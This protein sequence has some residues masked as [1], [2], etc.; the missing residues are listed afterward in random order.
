MRTGVAAGLLVAA[1]H[2][3]A[4]ADF[5]SVTSPDYAIDLYTGGAIGNSRIVGMGGASVATAEGSAGALTNAAAPAVR[6]ATSTTSWDWDF[7]ID[8]LSSVRSSDWD[9]NGES[10]GSGTGVGSF[11]AGLAFMLGNWGTA[12]TFTQQTIDFRI[13]RD[14]PATPELETDPAEAGAL[15]GKLAIAYALW[16]EQITVG[17]GIRVGTFDVRNQGGSLGNRQLF[18]LTGASLESGVVWR[19]WLSNLRVGGALAAPV[20][21]KDV[22][23]TGGCTVDDCYGYILPERIEVPWQVTAGAAYRFAPTQWNQWV[24]GH[25]RDERSLTLAADVVITGASPDAYGLEE[26]ANQKLQRSG[27]DVVVSIRG[28]AEFEW[29]PGRLRVRAGSYWEPGRFLD[30]AG[31]EV[32]GRL[33]GTFGIEVRWLQFA[34][35]GPHRGRISLTGDLASH[36]T[37]VGASIGFW[38]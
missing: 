17:G 12:L 35:W 30:R 27:R 8:Y 5:P 10:G 13:A 2:G 1:L 28:G 37:N 29:L 11:T 21:G 9:N 24:G 14:D 18:S 20:K 23:T 31:G 22:T 25:W 15:T 33:H 36:Y 3:R 6:P 19:P 32:G 26:F 4:V 34:L 16:H 7:H 38:H